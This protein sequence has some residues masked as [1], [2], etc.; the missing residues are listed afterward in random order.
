[1]FAGP[2]DGH[3][4]E[5]GKI[6]EVLNMFHDLRL[7]PTFIE[8]NLKCSE[9]RPKGFERGFESLFL[10]YLEEEGVDLGTDP[11]SKFNEIW[12]VFQELIELCD[13]DAESAVGECDVEDTDGVLEC[14]SANRVGDSENKR[15]HMRVP[16]EMDNTVDIT[17]GVDCP[18]A[19]N[20]RIS[21]KEAAKGLW[22]KFLIPAR[23]V[24]M[25]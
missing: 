11:Q 13:R 21:D 15:G 6:D 9:C 7:C 12:R 20:K 19:G 18:G 23:C 3:K 14:L 24:E 17:L 8:R 4:V 16:S 1:M 5:G 25:P 10:W 2:H 22:T